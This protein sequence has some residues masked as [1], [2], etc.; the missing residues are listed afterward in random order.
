MAK[1]KKETFAAESL[2]SLQESEYNVDSEEKNAI[3]IECQTDITSDFLEST[4]HELQCL[5]TENIYLNE[6]IR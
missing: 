2:F 3:G 4:T 6:E 5:R 1:R